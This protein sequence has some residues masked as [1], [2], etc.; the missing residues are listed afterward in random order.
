MQM[1][2]KVETKSTQP[3]WT[4]PGHLQG[5]FSLYAICPHADRN[6]GTSTE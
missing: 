5:H 4:K 2:L 1:S 3:K 6:T